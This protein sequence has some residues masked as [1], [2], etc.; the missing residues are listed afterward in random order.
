MDLT[1]KQT[2]V[3]THVS[4]RS[5]SALP[6]I[7]NNRPSRRFSSSEQKAPTPLAS[8]VNHR[9]SFN[10][11]RHSPI[12]IYAI[13]DCNNFFFRDLCAAG[14]YDPNPPQNACQFAFNGANIGLNRI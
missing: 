11:C 8:N 10:R 5:R 1:P 12:L 4:R 13:T 3:S 14:R 7:D 6:A 9:L 2:R